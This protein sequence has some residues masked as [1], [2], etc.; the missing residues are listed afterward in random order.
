MD[1]FEG[2]RTR[3]TGEPHPAKVLQTGN[4]PLTVR[5]LDFEVISEPW[6]RFQLKDGGKVRFRVTVLKIFEILDPDPN[7][8]GQ[9]VNRL[10]AEG[11]HMLFVTSANQSVV[12]T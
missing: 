3:M 12:S 1:P 10:D 8:I 6:G 7:N 2:V 4:G 5:E 11:E 9:F